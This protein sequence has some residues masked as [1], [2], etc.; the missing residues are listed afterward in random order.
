MSFIRIGKK[1]PT[2]HRNVSLQF[3]NKVKAPP[4][5]TFEFTRLLLQSIS[6]NISDSNN[7]KDEDALYSKEE[8]SLDNS[9]KLTSNS[10]SLNIRTKTISCK[11]TSISSNNSKASNC[12]SKYPILDQLGF[13]TSKLQDYCID[14]IRLK[15]LMKEISCIFKNNNTEINVE[16]WDSGGNKVLVTISSI[17]H[18][19]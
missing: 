10:C 8:P 18:L 19:R 14:T 12:Q 13:E 11:S 15:N 4:V 17:G 16:S 6:D 7:G 9:V 3:I 5:R 2:P 1:S